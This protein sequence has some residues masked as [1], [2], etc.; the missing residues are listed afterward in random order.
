MAG[1]VITVDF[2]LK[3]G[4]IDSFIPLILDNAA[5]SVR[6]EPGCRQFDVM[7]PTDGGNRVFLYEIYDDEAAFQAHLKTPHFLKFRDAAAGLFDKQT[8]NRFHLRG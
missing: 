7:T 4:A 1:Y 3:P 8:V 6:D 2:Q 5:A